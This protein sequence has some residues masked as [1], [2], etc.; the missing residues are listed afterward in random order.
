[1]PDASESL[2]GTMRSENPGHEI[3]EEGDPEDER[4][5]TASKER[6]RDLDGTMRT[7]MDQTMRIDQM[8]I[9]ENGEEE[10]EVE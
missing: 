3:I 10:A 9:D 5:G 4:T 7:D 8:H 6:E 1:M 2:A